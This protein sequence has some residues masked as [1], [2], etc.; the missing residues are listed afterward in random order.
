[1]GQTGSC[2]QEEEAIPVEVVEPVS[3]FKS[4]KVQSL[5]AEVLEKVR[6]QDVKLT[7]PEPRPGENNHAAHPSGPESGQNI[8]W[9]NT[10]AV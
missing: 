7:E 4:E 9:M 5:Q 2:C 8:K 1:M 6:G 3:A 10:L